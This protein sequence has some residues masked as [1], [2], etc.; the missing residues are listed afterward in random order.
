M[1]QF[2]SL[3]LSG[4]KSFVEPAE[5][6]IAPGLTG[7]VGPNGCGKSN[8]VEALRWVMGES[9]ARQMRA[10]EMEDVI[11]G[12]CA[13]R[14]A[15][16]LAEVTLC[17]AGPRNRV[18]AVLRAG[19]PDRGEGSG[20]AAEEGEVELDVRRRIERTKG[21]NYRVNGRE[22]R[23]RDV[24]LLFADAASGAR[25]AAMVTQGQV[26]ELI[27]ARP[28]ERR[29][30]LDEAAGISGIHPRRHEAE[31]RLR[32][33]EANL[34][35]LDD[36]LATLTAQHEHL[37]KQAR[38]AKRYRTVCAEIRKTEA[39]ILHNRWRTAEAE[40]AAAA[41]RLEDAE[42]AVA[43]ATGAAAGSAA[44][45]TE[46][47][48]CLPAL[49]AAE[50]EAGAAVQTLGLTREGLEAEAR[51]GEVEREAARRR[52]DQAAADRGRAHASAE[53]AAASLSRIKSE[54]ER[55]L[56]ASDGEAAARTAAEAAVGA[57]AAS[58]AEIDRRLAAVGERIAAG[59]ADRA[60]LDRSV[61]ELDSSL[62]RLDGRREE[63]DRQRRRLNEHAAAAPD[64]AAIDAAVE[65]AEAALEQARAGAEAAETRRSALAGAETDARD[66]LRRTEAALAAQRAE[67]GA[68]ERMVAAAGGG[69]GP[70]LLDALRPEPGWEHALAAGL[71]DDLTASTDPAQPIHWR[72]LPPLAVAPALPDG[73]RPLADHVA[74]PAQAARRL[75]QIGVVADADEGSRLQAALHPG[76]RLV[77]R[78]GGLWRWDGFTS[79][80]GASS[81]AAALLAQRNRLDDLCAARAAREG[82]H[83][84]A[85]R[86]A[87]DAGAAAAGAR[88]A[89]RAARERARAGEV[90]ATRAREARAKARQALAEVATRLAAVEEAAA[91]I[92]G[93]RGEI[94]AR[95]D[96]AARALAALP[97]VSGARADQVRL[98][99]A[100]GR[101][102][103]REREARA[104]FD[105]LCREIQGR[106]RRL[107]ALER[108]SVAWSARREQAL[109]QTA[110]LR[111]REEAE[112][113]ELTRLE[114]QP[115]E[116]AARR[117]ALLD[118]LEAATARR[119]QAGDALAVAEATL[120]EADRDARVAEKALAAAR[121]ERVRADAA[122]GQA[123]RALRDC[124]AVLAERLGM[125]ETAAAA[126][127]DEA[128]GDG[129]IGSNAHGDADAGAIEAAERRLERLKRERETMG[130]VNLRA[131]DEAT[132]AA[133]RI[134]SL[135]E[136][137]QDLTDAIAKLRRGIADLDREGRERLAA[138]F[139]A[140]D[141][142]FRTLFSRLFGGGQAYLA[143]SE[144][145]DPLE[146]GL[147]I[148]ACPPGKKLQVLS[149]LS[150]GEQVL[151][152]L[153]LRFAVF[154]TNPAPVCV[155]DEVDAPLDDANVDRFCSL[156]S[157]MA[158]YGT[159]FLVITHHRMT[160]ARMDRLF[161]VTMAERGVSQLVSVDLQRAEALR[162]TA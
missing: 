96:E 24:Q 162:E 91:A 153:A 117:S 110:E 127:A 89:E 131:E 46:A 112:R 53:D 63:C 155:L 119:R 28:A 70:R 159:R 23:A 14:P 102:R 143:L 30:L 144:A 161:G 65:E 92:V 124:A 126:L 133:D 104:A 71:G 111:A 43:R 55:L 101:E 68:L 78:D 51:R 18:P 157:E 12:G 8:L 32:A 148:M 7:I 4:F 84:E 29:L 125:D 41:R 50:A 94:A 99:E 37:R 48:A 69:S 40:V 113:A 19:G 58:V 152:A 64:L 147:E 139:A 154:L 98:R 120:A 75:G 56:V 77:G 38:Q 15:R 140:V 27:L 13:G 129:A 146:A 93:E 35:R 66:E 60:A 138:S 105:A 132:E 9:S 74:E 97:D 109:A 81:P 106:R 26:T 88:E 79:A 10:G 54:R 21:S 141:G 5:L 116:I 20:A 122:V 17:L 103:E 80:A 85:A 59:E 135:T 1:L 100:L 42:A 47:A 22:A 136:Q 83:A 142:H 121:E 160:M 87:G 86:R 82:E 45:Q 61:A 158:S 134:A 115:D 16:T 44:R 72:A 90:A 67:I 31:L 145:D 52:R 62:R 11:F 6:V 76:Q 123:E 57:A 107:D 73:V 151:T 36:V 39:G 49:R 150:G 33:A 149:L 3:R 95:R 108:D 130:P 128:G 34:E 2:T 156:L 137:R 114:A 25:S 118:A